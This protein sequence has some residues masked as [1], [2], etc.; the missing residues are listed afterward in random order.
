MTIKNSRIP[1]LN[2]LSL[3]KNTDCK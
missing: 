2:I 3:Y 1:Q